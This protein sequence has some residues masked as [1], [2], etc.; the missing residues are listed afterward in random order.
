MAEL[1]TTR[2]DGS[3]DEFL[4][5]VPDPGRRADAVAVC[6]L[7]AAVTGAPPAMWG[8]GIVGFG[9][10]RLRYDTGRELDWFD[11]GLSPRKQAL[12]LYL[13][14]ELSGYADLLDRLGPHR[15]GK[16]CLYVKRLADVDAGV[17]ESVLRRAVTET[18]D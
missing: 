16:G 15:L 3:V 13:P 9:S 5:A 4:A 10:R 1:K 18:E 7:M 11:V 2:N 6:S 12:T 8:V 17:L 14:G